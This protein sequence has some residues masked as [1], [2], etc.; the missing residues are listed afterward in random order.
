MRDRT[1]TDGLCRAARKRTGLLLMAFFALHGRVGPL[2]P[3]CGIALMIEGRESAAESVRRVAAFAAFRELSE[4]RVPVA[5]D[6]GGRER[7]IADEV[8]SGFRDMA[9]GAGDG[10][11]LARQ[12][13]ARF[14]VI[15]R[16]FLEC[17]FLMT[18]GAINL[19]LA[20]MGISRM[21]DPASPPGVFSSLP[22]LW[23]CW[24]FSAACLPFRGNFDL[25]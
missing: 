18:D 13:V 16:R 14:L 17:A 4:M 22:F 2:E 9:F 7:T 1:E 3:I 20:L 8:R 6:A 23:H 15:N 5:V 10:N 11:M 12:R 19:E 24:H 25:A 21:A